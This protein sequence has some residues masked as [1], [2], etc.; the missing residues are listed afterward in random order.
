MDNT[1]DFDLDVWHEIQ[2]FSFG[3]S[4]L[5]ALKKHRCPSDIPPCPDCEDVIEEE[6]YYN[7]A[8]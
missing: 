2:A 3:K 8:D 6:E 5:S 1:V 7:F 4:F